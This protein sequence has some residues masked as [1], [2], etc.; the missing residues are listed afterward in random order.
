MLALSLFFLLPT[1]FFSPQTYRRRGLRIKKVRLYCL[2]TRWFPFLF[3]VCFIFYSS[4]RRSPPRLWL[5]VSRWDRCSSGYSSSAHV[6]LPASP[7]GIATPSVSAQPWPTFVASGFPAFQFFSPFT[8]FSPCHLFCACICP[9]V[10]FCFPPLG[11]LFLSRI[12]HRMQL[13]V[14]CICSSGCF[15]RQQQ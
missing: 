2:F 3:C 4:V 9:A 7:S 13:I 10:L 8:F 14:S 12:P 1:S 11:A 6:P 15:F 5:V